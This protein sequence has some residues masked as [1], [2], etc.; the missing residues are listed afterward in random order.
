MA[1]VAILRRVWS[2][3]DGPGRVQGRD[4]PVRWQDSAGCTRS[5]RLL[6]LPRQVFVVTGAMRRPGPVHPVRAVVEDWGVSTPSSTLDLGLP[7]PGRG[8]APPLHEG[9]DWQRVRIPPTMT[10]PTP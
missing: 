4:A 2:F 6:L 3:T 5:G 1:R 10:E 8:Q 7:P 9:P